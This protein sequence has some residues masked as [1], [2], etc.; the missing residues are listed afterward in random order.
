MAVTKIWDV[1][2]RLDKPLS[3]IANPEKTINPEYEKAHLQALE[4][5]MSYAADEDKTEKHFYVS[6]I[7]CNTTC[8]RK[9]FQTVKESFGKEDGIV[10]YH[11]YQSFSPGETTPQEAHKIGLE[12]AEALWGDRFQVLVATHLNTKCLHNHFVINSISFKDGKRF[13][14]NRGTYH[15]MRETSDRI[16]R[17]HGLKIIEEP[18]GTREPTNLYRAEK[19]GIPTRYNLARAAIDE[20]IDKSFN[21]REFEY[22]LRKL[23]FYTQFNPK[24]KYWTVT[25][26]GWNKPIRL[27]RLGEEYTNERIVERLMEKDRSRMQ[28]F[29][30]PAYHRQYNLKSRKSRLRKVSGLRGL[31]LKYCYELGYLPR[32]NQ[33]PN[34]VHYLLKDDLL[35][36]EMLSRQARLLG[37]YQIDT[38]DDLALLIADKESQ[39]KILEDERAKLRNI[40]RR[41]IS[42]ADE[43]RGRSRITEITESL[44]PIRDEVR[45][46]KDILNRHEELEE[47]L[48][49]VKEERQREVKER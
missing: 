15:L 9:Q 42:E 4:D 16:C 44:K 28:T 49:K 13:R 41:V 10:A 7:N 17:E 39:I 5:V 25:P 36:C 38:K 23:G 31:Y 1:K 26:E 27:A 22:Y 37:K 32:Y 20:A 34:Q 33:K 3:Y 29:Q 40:V 30:R 6:G 46:C 48:E 47:K 19:A 14:D 24:R 18:H 21:L 11:G 12:L 8:A 35:R 43:A 2:G 45:L